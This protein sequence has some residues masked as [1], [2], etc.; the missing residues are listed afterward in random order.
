MK[1]KG[2]KHKQNER[3]LF[4]VKQNNRAAVCGCVT[5]AQEGFPSVDATASAHL[6]R[7]VS[8]EVNVEE[9]YST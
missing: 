9:E 5:R 8:R 2:R 1:G 3:M 7:I 4:E 6:E